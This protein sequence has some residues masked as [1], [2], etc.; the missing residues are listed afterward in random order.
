MSG[1]PRAA[2]VV[3]HPGH[4]LRLHGWL[5]QARPTVLVL[6]DGSGGSGRSRLDSSRRLLE[7]T[8]ARPGALF[9]AMTDD[10]LYAALLSGD[11]ELLR[12]LARQ[13]A[14]ALL[15]LDVELVVSDALEGFNPAHDL[16]RHLVDA[17]VPLAGRAR[18]RAPASYDFALDGPPDECPAGLEPRALRV[19]LDDAAWGRKQAAAGTYAELAGEVGAALRLADPDAFRVELLRPVVVAREPPDGRL[20][21]EETP[22]Y[23][24]Y[25]EERVRTGRFRRVLR[26][27][28][29]VR[30]AA[31]ALRALAAG[32]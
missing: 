18:G 15:E 12:G 14:G 27:A 19:A 16:C 7:A 5:E 4:E 20:P 25:G 10:A 32:G 2:L 26:F 3:A 1:W 28:D 23:E 8:G 11:L 29:H 17:A 13:V 30:P 21:G 9:G 24:R 31:E 6:T 22:R